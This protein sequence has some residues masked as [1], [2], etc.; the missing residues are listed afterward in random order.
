MKVPT[1]KMKIFFFLILTMNLTLVYGQAGENMGAN[2]VT[3]V[4]S[5]TNVFLRGSKTQNFL[6]VIRTDN[7]LFWR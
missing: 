7:T 1:G 2:I 4:S 5:A 3:Y 6:P